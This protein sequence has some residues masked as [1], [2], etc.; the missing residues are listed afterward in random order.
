MSRKIRCDPPGLAIR[1]VK[2]KVGNVPIAW[3][4]RGT[5]ESKLV[6]VED[7]PLM[8][9]TNPGQNKPIKRKCRAQSVH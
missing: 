4:P 1:V 7:L 8:T 9:Q 5:G 3:S 2:F 6:S